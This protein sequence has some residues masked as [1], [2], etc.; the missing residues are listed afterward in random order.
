MTT[1]ERVR[2][3]HVKMEAFRL[4]RERQ[5]TGLVGAVSIV[6]AICLVI[7]IFSVGGMHTGG[8]AGLYSGS[9][10]LFTDVGGYVLCAIISFTTAVILTVACIRLKEKNDRTASEEKTHSEIHHEED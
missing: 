7:L 2:S 6:L 9:T 5:K 10:M 1:E 4:E 3:L 8:P